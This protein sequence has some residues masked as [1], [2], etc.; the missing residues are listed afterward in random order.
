MFV[1]VGVAASAGVATALMVG[2]SVIP[3][4]LIQFKGQS[5]RG[6]KARDVAS[7]QDEEVKA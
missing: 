6:V 2:L 7:A 3:T 1:S 4:I 5:L